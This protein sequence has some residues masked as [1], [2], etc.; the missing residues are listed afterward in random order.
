MLWCEGELVGRLAKSWISMEVPLPKKRGSSPV[1]R[2]E[3]SRFPNTS[4]SCSCFPQPPTFLS[5]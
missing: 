4:G 5:K 3:V 1:G 2:N